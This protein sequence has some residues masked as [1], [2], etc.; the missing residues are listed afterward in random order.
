MTDQTST[1]PDATNEQITTEL[2]QVLRE[3]LRLLGKESPVAAKCTQQ[4]CFGLLNAVKMRLL[5]A[6]MPQADDHG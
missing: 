5:A 3:Y 6:G 2:D 4:H 1:T